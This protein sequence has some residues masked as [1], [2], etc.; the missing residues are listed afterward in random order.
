MRVAK[1]FNT[2]FSDV[3]ENTV[4]ISE[5]IEDPIFE[6]IHKYSKHQ[7]RIA[8]NEYRASEI[9]FSFN[10]ATQLDVL[11]VIN[12]ID[13]R[14][15]TSHRNMPSKTFKQHIDHANVSVTINNENILNSKQEKLLG[16]T[17]DYTFSCLPHV[18][19]IC[20]QASKKLHALSRICKFM[21]QDK[22]RMIIKAFIDTQFSYCPLLW[23]FHGNRGINNTLHKIHERALRRYIMM[24]A[25]LT[26]SFYLMITLLQFN[27]AI[28]KN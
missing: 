16:I 21:T 7:S 17:I 23:I 25:L 28:Y 9:K 27:N 12:D 4:L 3:V 6:A 22:H 19:N 18:R 15:A 5:H 20:K 24:T 8:I 10:T 14:K 26:M 2:Y 11:D 13:V 1:K